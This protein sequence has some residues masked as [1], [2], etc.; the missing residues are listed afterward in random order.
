MLVIVVVL[1]LPLA[2]GRTF[3]SHVQL[4]THF[5]HTAVQLRAYDYT[6][7]HTPSW[8]LLYPPPPVTYC[9]RAGAAEQSAID[10]WYRKSLEGSPEVAKVP[11]ARCFRVRPPLDLANDVPWRAAPA[12]IRMVG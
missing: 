5:L 12:S 8:L 11:E 6:H 2:R 10:S 3:F 4:T 1:K 7:A 9:E